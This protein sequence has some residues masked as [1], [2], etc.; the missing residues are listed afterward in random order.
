MQTDAVEPEPIQVDGWDAVGVLAGL[1]LSALIALLGWARDGFEVVS[2]TFGITVGVLGILGLSRRLRRPS[3]RPA[4]LVRLSVF[5]A[6]SA[7]VSVGIVALAQ[8]GDDDDASSAGQTHGPS[9]PS[10]AASGP[11]G[12]GGAPSSTAAR[13]GTARVSFSAREVTPGGSVTVSGSDFQPGEDVRVELFDGAGLQKFDGPYGL[14]DFP[15]DGDGVLQPVTVT[16]PDEICCA[17]ATVQMRVTGRS[18]HR[19]GMAVLTLK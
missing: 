1:V 11:G 2:W 15:A 5:V 17:G 13:P 3:G 10:A 7:A 12:V 19:P 9:S 4:R 8:R 6:V 16:V 18:S 14:G